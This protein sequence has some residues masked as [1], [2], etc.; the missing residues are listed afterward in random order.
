MEKS[1]VRLGII[2]ILCIVLDN[3]LRRVFFLGRDE[4]LPFSGLRA[5]PMSGPRPVRTSSPGRGP[6]YTIEACAI[7]DVELT[8]R[9]IGSD[10][11][12]HVA[13]P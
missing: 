7:R 4:L 13:I 9:I 10:G 12:G 8:F 11:A 2:K 3:F 6:V 5:F 1:P